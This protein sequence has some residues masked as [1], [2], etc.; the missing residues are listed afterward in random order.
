[1]NT[2]SSHDF[3]FLHGSWQVSHR[4]LLER[5]CGSEDWQAFKGTCHAYPV[6]GG[7]GNVDDNLLHLPA[8]SYRAAT[9]RTHDPQTGLW[10]IWWLDGRQPHRID[11]PVVGAFDQGIGTFFADDV[12]DGCAIRVRFRWS[13]TR[14]PS[15]LWEQAF[16]V[17]AGDTWEVNWCM[18]FHRRPTA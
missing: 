7:Q 5:L 8:G 6:L 16:S 11:V 2:S 1:M 13:D 9:L 18:R 14:T 10:A 12:I 3:D 15:P 17:D 4:R